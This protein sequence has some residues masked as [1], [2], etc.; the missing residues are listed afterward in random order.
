[1]KAAEIV[2]MPPLV[3]SRQKPKKRGWYWV[4]GRGVDPQI[5]WIYFI[6][7]VGITLPMH[8]LPQIPEGRHEWAGPIGLPAE[9]KRRKR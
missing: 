7:I 1:M 2:T 4:R 9:P 5:L 3:W 6:R 8:T